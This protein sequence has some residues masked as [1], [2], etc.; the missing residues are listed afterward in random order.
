MPTISS[1]TPRFSFVS[2][3]LKLDGQ[4]YTVKEVAYS[5][6]V[7]RG[8]VE[9]NHAIPLGF[10]RG[11]YEPKANI[12]LYYEEFLAIQKKLGNK[13]YET[14]FT[15]TVAYAEGSTTVQDE[16]IGCRFAK[17][18]AQHAKGNDNLDVK[19][20]LDLEYIKWN[21]A[22]PFTKMPGGQNAGAK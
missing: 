14:R 1:D 16:L 20:D 8:K 10:T 21:G 18:D 19:L 13:F 17:R 5:D 2:L 12:T 15:V 3:T 7:N 11:M 22:D 9:A 6:G 4:E